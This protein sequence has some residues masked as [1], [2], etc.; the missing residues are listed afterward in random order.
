[1]AEWLKA[2]A[3]K[4]CR[5]KVHAGSNPVLSAITFPKCSRT[6]TKNFKTACRLAGYDHFHFHNLRTSFIS[7]LAINNT[8]PK[9]I[10]ELARHSD[11]KI[12]SQHYLADDEMNKNL[13]ET[14]MKEH[15]NID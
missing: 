8:N 15:R 5:T 2:H 11:L 3:W 12:A 13:L 10:K 6:I 14:W 4:A 1:M 7:N 9:V